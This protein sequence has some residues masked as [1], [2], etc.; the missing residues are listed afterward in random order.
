MNKTIYSEEHKYIV[1][2]LKEARGKVHLTQKQ[3]AKLLGV[4]QSLEVGRLS[5]LK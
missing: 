3:V 2:R 1:A 5:G 4:T